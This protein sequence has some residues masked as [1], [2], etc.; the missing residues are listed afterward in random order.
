[1]PIQPVRVLLEVSTKRAFASALDWP[2]WTRSARV[3]A[4]AMEQLVAYG[5]RYKRVMSVSKIAF[6]PPKNTDALVV[7]ETTPGSKAT[8]FGSLSIPAKGDYEPIDTRELKRLIRILRACW[9]AF[10]VSAAAVGSR[11]LSTGPRGGGRGVQK[12]TDHVVGSDYGC[13]T[14]LGGRPPAEGTGVESLR[15]EFVLTI[16]SRASGAIPDRGPRGGHRYP[17]RYAIRSSA[18]HALDHAWELEDRSL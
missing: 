18:W 3:P 11:Q 5:D 7:V 6:A 12:M 2:G 16:K 17:I 9:A 10:D 8:D 4:E 15:D 14:S 1:M 13:L